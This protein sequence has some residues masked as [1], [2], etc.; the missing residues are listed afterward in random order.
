MRTAEPFGEPASHRRVGDRFGAAGANLTDALFP[1]RSRADL[2]SGADGD[3]RTDSI[4]DVRGEPHRRHAAE[5]DSAH[6]DPFHTCRVEHAHGIGAEIVERHSPGG[7]IRLAVSARVQPNDP[8]VFGQR[9]DLRPP[10]VGGRPK[11]AEQQQGGCIDRPVGAPG[12]APGGR[13]QGLKIRHAFVF[14]SVAARTRA[15]NR[16]ETPR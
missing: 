6:G 4:R 2:Q 13:L 16:A 1:H 3:E 5:R 10:D 11:R 15:T 7:R 14:A 9:L 8:I 12:D